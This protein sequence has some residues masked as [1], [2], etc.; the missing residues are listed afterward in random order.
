M[1]KGDRT[2]CLF[3]G[4]KLEQKKLLGG[5]KIAIAYLKQNRRNSNS[6]NVKQN[7]DEMLNHE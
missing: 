4:Q 3:Y 1:K 5:K 2:G 6:K 7:R